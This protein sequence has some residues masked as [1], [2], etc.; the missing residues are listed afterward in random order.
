MSQE[1]DGEDN[2]GKPL[3]SGSRDHNN[4]CNATEWQPV[5][6]RNFVQLFIHCLSSPVFK[7]YSG[8]NQYPAGRPSFR[9][10]ENASNTLLSFSRTTS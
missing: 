3:I 9:S 10:S 6:K 2:G 8:P 1:F 7:I 4:E 5:L